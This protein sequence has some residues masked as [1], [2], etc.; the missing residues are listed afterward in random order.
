MLGGVK[1]V[2]G[3]PASSVIQSMNTKLMVN[4]FPVT[5]TKEMITKI[6]E[7]FGKVK[8]VDL[9]KDTAT[10]EFRGTVNVEY[11]NEMDA[12]KGLTGMMGL[13]VED[14]ILFVKRLTTIS[15]PTTN[16]EGEVFKALIEDK[17]TPCLVLKNCVKLE[18][19]TERDDYKELEASVEEEMSRFGQVVKVHCPR[20]PLFGDPMQVPGVGKVYVRFTNEE[21]S[22]KAKHVRP[23]F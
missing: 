6:C 12:K 18:E 15:A 3:D 14:S 8:S 19:M 2:F 1:G 21:D 17:P 9:L 13:K 4:N 20:P 11:E 22:E 16:L 7:V 5:H 23:F 10:G